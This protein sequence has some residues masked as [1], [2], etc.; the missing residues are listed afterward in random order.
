VSSTYRLLCLNHDPAIEL[1]QEWHSGSGTAVADALA[2]VAN[3]P[4]EHAGCDLV[5]GRYSYPLIEVCC[6]GSTPRRP[7][8]HVHDPR[9]IDASWLRLL[10]AARKVPDLAELCR[11]VSVCWGEQRLALLRHELRA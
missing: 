1:D 5:I 6:P 9:W 8:L 3:P 4:A 2:A 7:H 10:L 11:P